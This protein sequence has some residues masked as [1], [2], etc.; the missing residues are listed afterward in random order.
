MFDR[1]VSAPLRRLARR[2]GAALAGVALAAGMATGA[3]E[4][5]KPTIRFG[6]PT[7]TGV[8]VKSEVAAQILEHMGYATKQT[9][10]SPAVAL[11]TIKADELD[12]YLGGWM[13]TEKDMI[14]PLVE[15]NQA[16][17]LTTNISDAIMGLAVPKYVWEAG[18]KSEADLAAHAGKFDSKIYGIEA[19]S[20]FNKSIKEAIANDRHGLGGWE[21]VPSSTSGMLAQVERMIQKEEWI[22]FLGWEPHWMNIRFDIKYL[23][24]VG[25]P[26]IAETTSDVLTVANV[27]LGDRHPN[28][29]KFFS[30]YVVRKDEQSKWVLDHGQKDI[31]AETVAADWIADNLDRVSEFLD[32]VKARDGRPAIE[33]VKAAVG[34]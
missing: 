3:A 25:E 14:D 29:E 17:V 6:V 1:T 23:E 32:G 4:A 8:T 12:I 34:S 31:E 11:N 26:K 18:V 19:G 9:T 7:W 21:L 33:A 22:V 20:G 27:K 13:P 24:A 30:Q 15:K 2:T 16:K 5:D 10:A 28:V